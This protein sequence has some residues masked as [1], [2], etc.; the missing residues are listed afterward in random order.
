MTNLWNRPVTPEEEA[1]IAAFMKRVADA[2]PGHLPSLPNADAVWLKAQLLRRWDVERKV[3]LP[4]DI[5]EPVQLAAGLAM[6]SLLLVWS[7]PSLLEALTSIA[8]Q[9][10]GI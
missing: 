2:V 5:M 3:Q 9:V 8:M 6:A 10:S 1:G 4:L 7:L